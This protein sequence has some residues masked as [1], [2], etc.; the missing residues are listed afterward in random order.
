MSEKERRNG[1]GRREVEG[2]ADGGVFLVVGGGDVFIFFVYLELFFIYWIDV[3]FWSRFYLC[4]TV[5][6]YMKNLLFK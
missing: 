2:G 1:R 3:V 4:I 5:I 6:L